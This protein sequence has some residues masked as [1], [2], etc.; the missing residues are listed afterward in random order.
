MENCLFCQIVAGSKPAFKVYEDNQFLGFLDVFPKAYGH[1]L[2]IPKKH[3]EWFWQMD[4][5]GQLLNLAKKLT[6]H[7]VEIL[8]LDT[9]FVKILGK[10]VPHTHVHLIPAPKGVGESVAEGRNIGGPLT[11]QAGEEIS[12]RL[13][14][15]T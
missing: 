6:L 2:I 9:C 3:S 4:D 15:N 14:L 11:P 13:H 12:Q 5:P 10:A 1:T 7:Y 8:D